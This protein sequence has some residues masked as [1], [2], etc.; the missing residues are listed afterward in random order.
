[1]VPIVLVL[2]LGRCPEKAENDDEDE[3]EHDWDPSTLLRP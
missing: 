2:F 3:D 1:L